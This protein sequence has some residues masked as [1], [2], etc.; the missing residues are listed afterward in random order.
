MRKTWLNDDPYAVLPAALDVATVRRTLDERGWELVGPVTTSYT[1]TEQGG[2]VWEAAAQPDWSRYVHDL[3]G[4]S[5]NDAPMTRRV[6]AATT[7]YARRYVSYICARDGV[8]EPDCEVITLQ[9]W[10]ATSWKTLPSGVRLEFRDDSF[11]RLNLGFHSDSEFHVTGARW[12]T[13]PWE[14]T[15][16]QGTED[17]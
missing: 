7:E 10:Q 15:H 1:L 5:V 13:R 11:F 16:E 14:S 2:A 12:Y 4:S 8:G 6:E 9:P 3:G 17:D